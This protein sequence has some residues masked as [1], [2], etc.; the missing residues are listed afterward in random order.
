MIRILEGE[1]I[2]G[3]HLQSKIIPDPTYLVSENTPE[4]EVDGLSEDPPIVVEIT[5][6]LRDQ[7]KIEKFL[8]KKQVLE[9]FH[10]V[11]FRGFFVASGSELSQEDKAD[12]LLILKQNNC[13]LI[14]L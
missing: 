9:E 10:Q 11:Q 14:N 7:F 2:S 6:I 13:E 5:S 3:V 4:F 8:R 12:I 1:G